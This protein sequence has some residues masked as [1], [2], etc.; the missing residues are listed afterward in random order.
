MYAAP[1]HHLHLY[2]AHMYHVHMYA[3]P[4]YHVRVRYSHVS[5]MLS[6]RIKVE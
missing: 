2:A 3:A 5:W 4:M 6:L 1:M